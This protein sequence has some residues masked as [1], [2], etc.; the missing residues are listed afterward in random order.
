MPSE[1]QVREWIFAALF[2]HVRPD[3]LSMTKGD[4]G[5][6]IIVETRKPGT[7]AQPGEVFAVEVRL[8]GRD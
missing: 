7:R 4:D 6:T 5:R 3:V 2:H 1:K 8:Q